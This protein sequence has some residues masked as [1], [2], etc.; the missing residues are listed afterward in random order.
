MSST[1]LRL[2]EEKKIIRPVLKRLK[3]NG[4]TV[5]ALGRQFGFK[6]LEVIQPSDT[7]LRDMI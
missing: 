7:N 4:E 6:V 3:T 2:R 5:E 1:D